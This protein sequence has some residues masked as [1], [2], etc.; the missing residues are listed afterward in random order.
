MCLITRY[1]S[2]PTLLEEFLYE[3]SAGDLSCVLRFVWCSPKWLNFFPLQRFEFCKT[4][5]KALSQLLS[6]HSSRFFS[7]SLNRHRQ[8]HFRLQVIKVKSQ[9]FGRIA[10][11][12]ESE[13]QFR[14]LYQI[15]SGLPIA[16]K[17][18][19]AS[20]RY[21]VSLSKKFFDPIVISFTLNI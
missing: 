1:G 4:E 21:K 18:I 7:Q 6:P 5:T 12:K 20:R 9:R 8:S 2:L 14:I 3:I 15:T 19:Q 16:T 11:L 13:I 10:I 17:T